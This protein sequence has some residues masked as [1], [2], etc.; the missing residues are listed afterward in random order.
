ML[1]RDL[2]IYLVG[3]V[4]ELIV[5][6]TGNVCGVRVVVVEDREDVIV[7][8]LQTELIRPVAPQAA[9]ST[10]LLTKAPREAVVQVV[11]DIRRDHIV[12][13]KAR[14]VCLLVRR[15]CLERTEARENLIRAR[16]IVIASRELYSRA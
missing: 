3:I 14:I 8:A 9:D 2:L 13:R 10:I 4:R 6:V 11:K 7:H 16:V 12:E 15:A 5:S 1:P